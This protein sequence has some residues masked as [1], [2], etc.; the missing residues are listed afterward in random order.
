MLRVSEIVQLQQHLRN[1]AR[2]EQ[3]FSLHNKP[4]TLPVGRGQR[5]YR[6]GP[7]AATNPRRLIDPSRPGRRQPRL[8]EPHRLT[9]D[10]A[11]PLERKLLPRHTST[12]IGSHGSLK[13]STSFSIMYALRCRLNKDTRGPAKLRKMY[14]SG[15]YRLFA[16][17]VELAHR[18]VRELDLTAGH[19]AA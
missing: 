10:V 1:V 8:H 18:I 14:L 2:R 17:P 16:L 15:G 7:A 11:L 3:A 12:L 5:H 9:Q 4:S 6:V 13:I 19:W